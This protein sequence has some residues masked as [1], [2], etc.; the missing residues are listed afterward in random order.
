MLTGSDWAGELPG[1]SRWAGGHHK[2]LGPVPGIGNILYRERTASVMLMLTGS[3]WAGGLPGDSR[4]AGG[5][6]K[7]LGP[8]PGIGDIL[9]EFIWTED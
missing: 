1:D 5:H 8:V 3:D 7:K 4:W 2:K 6:H 9:S